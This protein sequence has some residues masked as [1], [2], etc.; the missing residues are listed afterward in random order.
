MLTEFK[1]FALKGNVLDLAVGVVV[2]A[3]FNQ[4]VNSLVN[5]LL[6]PP[7][8]FIVGK[9]DFSSLYL[10]LSRTQYDSLAAARE[11]GAPVI[12]YGAFLNS[13]INFLI[14]TFAVFLLVRQVNRWRPTPP[15]EPAKTKEC[16]YCLSTIPLKAV[17]CAHCTADLGQPP[18]EPAPAAVRE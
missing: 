15:P 10:N 16:P 14:V 9:V 7:L 4:I 17:R 2:G 1:R 5:D 6:M 3:A 13:V 12:A 8:G 18:Q 11:A